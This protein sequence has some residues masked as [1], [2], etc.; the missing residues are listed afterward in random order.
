MR[1]PIRHACNVLGTLV[2]VL[3][4]KK[5]SVINFRGHQKGKDKVAKRNKMADETGKLAVM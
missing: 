5:V 4:P 1:S 3:L 2:A